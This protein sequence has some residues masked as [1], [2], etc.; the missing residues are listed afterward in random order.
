M[1]VVSCS[2]PPDLSTRED[3]LRS[4]LSRQLDAEKADGL[5]SNPE[6]MER[7]AASV[8]VVPKSVFASCRPAPLEQ[9]AAVSARSDALAA[10]PV[11]SLSPTLIYKR[12]ELTNILWPEDIGTAHQCL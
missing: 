7:P 4:A 1:V 10:L 11:A 5:L 3:M 9:A 12:R 6:A 2:D 8:S